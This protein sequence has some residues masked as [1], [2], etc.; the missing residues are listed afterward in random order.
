[1]AKHDDNATGRATWAG[2][3]TWIVPGLGH[4]VLGHRG[5]AIVFFV[6][7]SL[8]YW[9]GMALGGVLDSASLRTN[10]WLTAAAMGAGGYTTPC[11]LISSA[12]DARLLREAGLNRMPDSMSP[13]P[14]EREASRRFLAVR[15]Q[16][17]AFHPGADV[18]Q[19]YLAASG[20]MNVLAILDAIARALTGGLPTFRREL[21]ASES[22]G[23]VTS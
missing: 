8:P 15:A 4:Y 14:A 1:M 16:Y 7:I 5:L 12:I 22:L 11:I 17:M 21:H 10:P 9:I 23:G 6:A 18:A 3:L 13:N 2:L 19:I 20:L